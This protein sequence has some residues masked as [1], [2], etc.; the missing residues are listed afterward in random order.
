MPIQAISSQR[1]YQ[2]AA[3]QMTELIKAGEYPPGAKLPGERDFAKQLGVS[4]PTV[5]E[6]LIALEISGLIEVRVNAGAYVKLRSERGQEKATGDA[7]S[8]PYELLA[9]RKLIEPPVAALAAQSATKADL[10]AIHATLEMIDTHKKDH[11]EKLE[12]DRLF[13]TRIA[14]ATHNAVVIDVIERL[15]R[16]MYGPIFALL[17]E[18]TQLTN[19]QYM[20]LADHR[21][22]YG[23]IARHDPAAAHAAMLGHLIN[24]ELTLLPTD[25]DFE[26]SRAN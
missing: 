20:T 5:R 4:R 17:S 2:K 15:W 1:L 8:S 14:E 19:K 23:C 13:H 21:S 24:V 18:R 12:V 25:D 11:W 3:E 26:D 9:A 6:A 10:D 7:G 16:E 22:I